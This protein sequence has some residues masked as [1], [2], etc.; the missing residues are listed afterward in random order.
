LLAGQAS[1]TMNACW[2]KQWAKERPRHHR[3]V[4]GDRMA[5]SV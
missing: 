5:G 2:R 1:G 3:W 4:V